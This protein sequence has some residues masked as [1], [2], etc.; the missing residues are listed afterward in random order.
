MNTNCDKKEVS[1]VAGLDDAKA[2]NLPAEN[3]AAPARPKISFRA[4]PLI[5]AHIDHSR[6]WREDVEFRWQPSIE[7]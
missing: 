5:Q 1:Q 6:R 4:S 3:S 7:D 2:Q